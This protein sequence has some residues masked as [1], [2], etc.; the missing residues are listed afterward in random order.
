MSNLL[1]G[2]GNPIRPN[3]R[4]GKL[5]QPK[6]KR[7]LQVLIGSPARNEV[8]TKYTN[9]L[10]Q[11]VG[12]MSRFRPDIHIT[13]GHEEGSILVGQRR[14]VAQ[15][16]VDHDMDWI[17]WIDS[18]MRFPPEALIRLLT[19]RKPIVAANY[20][21]R[22]L[23][24]IPVTHLDDR[25]NGK[26]LYTRPEDTGLV[27]VAST[28]M[29]LM[30][31]AVEVFRKTPQPWFGEHWHEEHQDYSGEDVWFC[32][33]ARENGFPVYIDQDLSQHVGHLG[34][35]EFTNRMAVPPEDENG[36]LRGPD[37]SDHELHDAPSGA[38]VLAE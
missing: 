8:K 9:D 6:P 12:K 19:H 1:D 34:E 13:V 10:V 23:P 36:D 25:S 5:V 11:M 17:L 28:G 16:A 38:G 27:E 15:Y 33:S 7:P 3:A 2:Y 35:V 18:D 24:P 4:K 26:R 20:V 32:R 21:T 14:S 30:L 29:G 31:T 37:S 22:T